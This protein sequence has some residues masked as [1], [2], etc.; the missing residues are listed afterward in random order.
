MKAADKSNRVRPED[1]LAALV[2]LRLISQSILSLSG[3][4]FLKS[5]LESGRGIQPVCKLPSC[6][7]RKKGE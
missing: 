6:H 3:V 4:L 2:V 1:F 5:I 7:L